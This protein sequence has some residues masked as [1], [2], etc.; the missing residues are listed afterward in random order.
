MPKGGGG[1]SRGEAESLPFLVDPPEL[2]KEG[3]TLHVHFITYMYTV[4]QNLIFPKSTI[5]PQK[6]NGF[7]VLLTQFG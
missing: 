6:L 2:C 1:R 4:Y 5:R 7:Y 3:K